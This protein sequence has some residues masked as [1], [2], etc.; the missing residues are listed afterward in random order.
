MKRIRFFLGMILMLFLVA[1]SNGKIDLNGEWDAN[2][3]DGV[4]S[5]WDFKD[6]E[7]LTM[8]FGAMK[9]SYEW[10]IEDNQLRL[11]DKKEGEVK[12]E[13]IYEIEKESK[14]DVTLYELDEEGK[15][16][17]GATIKLSK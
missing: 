15:R 7:L 14:D 17:E 1:C 2:G 12:R 16:V 3:S 6:N 9:F 8:D 4:A 13:Y 5:S 11:I 10:E